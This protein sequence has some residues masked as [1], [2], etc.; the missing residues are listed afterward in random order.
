MQRRAGAGTEPPFTFPRPE[1][2]VSTLRWLVSADADA[3]AGQTLEVTHGMEVPAESRADLVSWPDMR[4][5]DLGSRVV[6]M[7]G[8]E[9]IDEALAFA[10]AHL[11]RGAQVVLAFRQLEVLERA[12]L[13]V[14]ERARRPLHLLHADPLKRE[15]VQ[16]ASRFLAD[17]Y[18]RL[19][20]VLVLPTARPA[21][22]AGRSRRCPTTRSG[23]S[24]PTRWWR[25]SR[26]PRRSRPSSSASSGR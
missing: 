4:L 3:F 26:S 23:A 21:P 14:V 6:L 18:G 22:G 24:W 8:G 12:R 17:R 7:V 16:R 13:R 9:D 10:N 1:D 2:V 20:A 11:D 25:P 5:V 15:S 19:D